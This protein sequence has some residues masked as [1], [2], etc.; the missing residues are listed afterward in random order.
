MQDGSPVNMTQ[1]ESII[2]GYDYPY[3]SI[4]D[5]PELSTNTGIDFAQPLYSADTVPPSKVIDSKALSTSLQAFG[6]QWKHI[7]P[8][9][10][11]TQVPQG[12]ISIG[13]LDQDRRKYEV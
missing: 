13:V 4:Q 3:D 5:S 12:L 7:P 10:K 1:G 11:W 9:A 8:N 6:S 2:G